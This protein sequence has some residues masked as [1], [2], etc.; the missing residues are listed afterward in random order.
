[1]FF[2]AGYESLGQGG[3]LADVG[4]HGQGCRV[5]HFEYVDVAF[6]VLLLLAE[7]LGGWGGP[8]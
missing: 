6:M 4:V 2:D 1:M 8:W 5:E 7:K 3:V